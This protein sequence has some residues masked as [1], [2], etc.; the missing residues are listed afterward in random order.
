MATDALLSLLLTVLAGVLVVPPPL[1]P[2]LLPP[3][4]QP[5]SVATVKASARKIVESRLNR[6]EYGGA[7]P[8]AGATDIVIVPL[9]RNP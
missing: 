2:P 8:V 3:L 1:L 4:P 5:A 9:N 6:A 7:K